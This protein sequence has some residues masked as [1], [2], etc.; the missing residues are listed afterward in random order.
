MVY[1]LCFNK[2]VISGKKRKL[3]EG[4]SEGCEFIKTNTK[5]WEWASAHNFHC[6]AHIASI[7]KISFHLWESPQITFISLPTSLFQS[8]S[9]PP[10][11]IA[12]VSSLILQ[13]LC[14]STVHRLIFVIRVIFL[15]VQI[16][17]HSQL[18]ILH[19]FPLP[20]RTNLYISSK[21]LTKPTRTRLQYC[22]D[23]MLYFFTW[24]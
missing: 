15:S 22:I 19:G 10:F 3:V 13:I 6:K 4:I 20:P 17:Y 2:A 23:S 16:F 7:S 8:P 21:A 18:K 12:L 11:I 9:F 1:D 24:V 5:I 14:L